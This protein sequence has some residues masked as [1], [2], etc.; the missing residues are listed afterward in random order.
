MSWLA[1]N[2]EICLLSAR[3][4]PFSITPGLYVHV[5]KSE[6]LT[7][8]GFPLPPCLPHAW[9][10]VPFRAKLSRQPEKMLLRCWFS[11]ALS[12]LVGK[13][14]NQEFG[15]GVELCA[16]CHGPGPIPHMDMT[17][18]H[19]HFLFYVPALIRGSLLLNQVTALCPIFPSPANPH[20]LF[21]SA[22]A[23]AL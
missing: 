9:Q 20:L 14:C 18:V 6:Q 3:L 13:L 19:K 12:P 10:Q 7:G 2:S 17:H 16:Y 1:W 23:P 21:C 11:Q 15:K 8:V 22:A 4:M 5:L